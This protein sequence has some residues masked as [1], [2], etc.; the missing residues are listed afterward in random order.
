MSHAQRQLCY[1][2][3]QPVDL[4]LGTVYYADHGES[5]YCNRIAVLVC[6]RPLKIHPPGRAP[7][8]V[9]SGIRRKAETVFAT[10]SPPLSPLPPS[11]QLALVL[12][13]LM[14]Q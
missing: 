5:R 1:S 3:H 11:P 13:D 9:G 6:S 10:L 2:C 7:V 4:L 12:L 8:S 14:G